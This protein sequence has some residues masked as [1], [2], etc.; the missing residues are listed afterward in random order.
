MRQQRKEFIYQGPWRHLGLDL[1]RPNIKTELYT[2]AGRRK[3][4]WGPASQLLQRTLTRHVL[5]HSHIA[6]SRLIHVSHPILVV[7]HSCAALYSRQPQRRE[8]ASAQELMSA[9]LHWVIGATLSYMHMYVCCTTLQL[10]QISHWTELFIQASAKIQ[11]RSYSF[12]L[13]ITCVRRRSNA[14]ANRCKK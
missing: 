3:S 9:L 1:K 4:C 12:T 7:L 8:A 5:L 2:W 11:D 13:S 14:C 6:S 10:P